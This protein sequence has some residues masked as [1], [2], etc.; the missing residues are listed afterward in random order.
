MAVSKGQDGNN[1][2]CP[3]SDGGIDHRRACGDR[4]ALCLDGKARKMPVYH[5]CGL[6]SPTLWVE[7]FGVKSSGPQESIPVS[8]FRVERRVRGRH[9][10]WRQDHPR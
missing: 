5:S 9:D 6:R 7:S 2:R 4:N 8:V 1:T 3:G 10:G